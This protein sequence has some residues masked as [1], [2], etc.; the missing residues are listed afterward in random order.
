[1]N[2]NMNMNMNLNTIEWREGYGEKEAVII[3]DSAVAY[4]AYIMTKC[5]EIKFDYSVRG[6]LLSLCMSL[7]HILLS[8]LSLLSLRARSLSLS[9]SLTH[10]HTHTH[11]AS[12]SFLSHLFN[13]SLNNIHE[14]FP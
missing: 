13:I 5:V 10:T 8:L 14:K 6:S 7:S 11:T 2:E 12:H 9:L 4:N 3:E 1:M